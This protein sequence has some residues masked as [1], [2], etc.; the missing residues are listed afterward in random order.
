MGPSAPVSNTPDGQPLHSKLLYLGVTSDRPRRISNRLSSAARC[1]PS[2]TSDD[3]VDMPEYL[4]AGLTK[5][6]SRLLLRSLFSTST[7]T[8]HHCCGV[9]RHRTEHRPP[10]R[11]R[12]L[13]CH[14]SHV[15]NPLSWTPWLLLGARTMPQTLPTPHSPLFGPTPLQRSDKHTSCT[16][17][18]ALALRNK[19]YREHKANMFL[20]LG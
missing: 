10:S 5:I 15:R 17:K 4:P 12:P 2:R 9:P 13:W 3:T 18:R 19:N 8:I 14:R 16:D 7:S 1:S 20:A 11:P 6:R